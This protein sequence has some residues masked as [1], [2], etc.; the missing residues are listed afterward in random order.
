M[1]FNIKSIRTF[2]GAKDFETSRNF[3]LDLGFKENKVSVNMSYFYQDDFGF[4]LQ[5]AFVKDWIDNSM[6]FIEVNNLKNLLKHISS[7]NLNKKYPNVRLSDIVY[8]DWGN[9]FFLHDPS[10]VLWHFGTFND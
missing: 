4:Y 3:Y 8:N 2:V 10:G 9:E 5:D 7:L 6:V 1:T